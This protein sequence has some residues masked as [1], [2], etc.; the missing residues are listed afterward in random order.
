[1]GT[2]VLLVIPYKSCG[3]HNLHHCVADLDDMIIFK[4]L[5]SRDG[6][7]LPH[8]TRHASRFVGTVAGSKKTSRRGTL[9]FTPRKRPNYGLPRAG[10]ENLKICKKVKASNRVILPNSL[11]RFVLT[12]LDIRVC[13]VSVVVKYWKCRL[14]CAEY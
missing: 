5:A 4:F 3:S 14:Q 13:P 9:R 1:M 6:H 7:P 10:G 2:T 11:T 12:T 8:Y